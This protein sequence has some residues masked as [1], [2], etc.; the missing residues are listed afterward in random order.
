MTTQEHAI[1]EDEDVVLWMMSW[2][3]PA[4]T[5][6]IAAVC[7]M[8]SVVACHDRLWRYHCWGQRARHHPRFVLVQ[9]P[10]DRMHDVG[11]L[12]RAGVLATEDDFEGWKHEYL[13]AERDGS[14]DHFEDA[15]ELCS[16]RFVYRR[17]RG[18]DRRALVDHFCFGPDGAC[19]NHP[20]NVE[21]ISPVHFPFR[22]EWRFSHSSRAVEMGS[23]DEPFPV[24]YASREADWSWRL[25]NRNVLLTE[26]LAG[27]TTAAER[28]DDAEADG[29]ESLP[30]P[31][32][33]EAMIAL[34][35]RLNA[36]AVDHMANTDTAALVLDNMVFMLSFE[37]AAD[38]LTYSE[39][40]VG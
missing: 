13:R 27:C 34:E 23:A 1:F 15:A 7:R 29:F 24:L 38:E 8:F 33:A 32:S 20:M 30:P 18:P 6:R 4:E 35:R 22:F 11:D 21:A 12:V 26:W 31:R 39:L 40:M 19:D 16:L 17:K 14:R 3:T 25:E 2:L 5:C 37:G 36:P 10:I 9:D 28:G